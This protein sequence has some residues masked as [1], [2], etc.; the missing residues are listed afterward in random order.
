MPEQKPE[1]RNQNF[2][3]VCTGYTEKIRRSAKR[4][5]ALRCRKHRPCVSGCPVNIKFPVHCEGGRGRDFEAAYRNHFARTA[6]CLQS[7]DV[8]ARRKNQCQGECVHGK[9]GEPVAIGRLERFVADWHAANFGDEENQTG[10]RQRSQGCSHRRRSCG[11][12]PARA[13][14]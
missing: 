10:G 11:D 7:A 6:P 14:W 13:I 5:A 1:V 12:L 9:K 4:C 3:E 2:L 8:S